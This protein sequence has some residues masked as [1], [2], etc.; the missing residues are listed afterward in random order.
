MRYASKGLGLSCLLVAVVSGLGL[1]HPAARAQGS[2]GQGQAPVPGSRL[3]PYPIP[4]GPPPRAETA[5]WEQPG[6]EPD[7]PLRIMPP[8]VA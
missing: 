1:A 7:Y 8:V 6:R 5:G 4:G 3:P 2:P